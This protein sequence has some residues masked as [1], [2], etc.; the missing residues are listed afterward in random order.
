[1]SAQDRTI[2]SRFTMEVATALGAAAIGAVVIYGATEH[3]IGW[4]DAGP[5][6][7]YVPFWLGLIIMGASLAVLVQTLI[8]RVGVG[9][10]FITREQ[11][12]RIAAFSIPVVL[13]VPVALVLGLYVATAIYL[14]ATTTLQGRFPLIKAVPIAIAAPVVMFVLFERWFQTPL[15]KG[16]LEAAL[17]LY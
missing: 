12:L 10:T 15:L 13:F 11:G 3:S 4:G 1:M 2:V 7:G 9:E 6:P 8:Q 5:E 17:G 16:P 14:L